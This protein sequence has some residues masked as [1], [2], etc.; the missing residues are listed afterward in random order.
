M[1]GCR[2]IIFR[3]DSITAGLHAPPGLDYVSLVERRL[4]PLGARVV[5]LAVPGE[6]A[7]EM[8]ARAAAE[9]DPLHEPRLGRGLVVLLAGTND[10]DAGAPGEAIL[11][12]IAAFCRGRRVRGF[13][14]V[15]ATLSPYG[16]TEAPERLERE[17]RALNAALR[18]GW[19]G[20]ADA[21]ADVGGDPALDDPARVADP[22]LFVDRV[23]PAAAGHAIIARHVGDAL[24]ALL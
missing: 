21:L 22:A 7:S 15:A 24:A 9:I 4:A 1:T 17:R 19:R 23:H 2:L 14:V 13:A 20:F 3:G 11:D 12:S 18:A 5:R 16:A 6:T 10:L 8:A